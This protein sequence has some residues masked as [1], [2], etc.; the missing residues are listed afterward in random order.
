MQQLLQWKSNN[1]YILL[2]CFCS[3]MYT[4]R[5]A[6]A[7]YFHL[8]PAPLYNIFICGLPRSTIFS[9]VACPAL[10][11]FHLWS[12]PLYNIFICGLPRSTI[13][14]SVAC[15]ALQYFHL[16]PAP[17]Y[18][19][20]ICGLPRSTIFSSVVCPALQYFHLWPAPLYNIFICGLPR[21]T[22][23]S[24][25]TSIRHDIR[26]KKV[27]EH[28]MCFEFSRTLYETFFILRRT[29]RDMIENIYRS[30]CKVPVI[31]VRF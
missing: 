29:K 25:I 19:I 30:S 20:F 4:K 11:Y 5:N 10:Q 2:V 18:N 6:H 17:L 28:K 31:L 12:A 22:L 24:H 7:Q 26:Q 8:W 3:L 16:W 27:T 13:F 23:F 14:S 15:P 9:S 1:Y 21:S